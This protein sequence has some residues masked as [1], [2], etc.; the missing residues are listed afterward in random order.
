[1]YQTVVDALMKIPAETAADIVTEAA[2]LLMVLLAG[3]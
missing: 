1:V 2:P 3:G